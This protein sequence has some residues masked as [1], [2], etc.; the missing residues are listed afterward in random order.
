MGEQARNVQRCNLTVKLHK[1]SGFLVLCYAV[2]LDLNQTV[3]LAFEMSLVVYIPTTTQPVRN[4][5]GTYKH[6][7]VTQYRVNYADCVVLCY[8]FRV[9]WVSVIHDI[10]RSIPQ[11]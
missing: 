4:L 7:A 5:F 10:T 6:L 3:K 2:V 8:L 11:F 9:A 1:P